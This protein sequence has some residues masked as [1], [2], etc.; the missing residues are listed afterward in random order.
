MISGLSVQ[1]LSR[2]LYTLEDSGHIPPEIKGG[3]SSRWD[4]CHSFLEL[5]RGPRGITAIT[6]ASHAGGQQSDQGRDQERVHVELEI[7]NMGKENWIPGLAAVTLPHKQWFAGTIQVEINEVITR[8]RG[9][10][11]ITPDLNAGG[12]RSDRGRDQWSV[13]LDVE[14]KYHQDTDRLVYCWNS[15][16]AV[17]IGLVVSRL[18][19]MLH[20]QEV[21]GSIPAEIKAGFPALMI[22][23]VVQRLSLLLNAQEVGCMILAEIKAE[24]HRP[25]SRCSGSHACLTRHRSPVK[26]RLRWIVGTSRPGTVGYHVVTR[27]SCRLNKQE[28]AGV[29]SAEII[30]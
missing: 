12:R 30:E 11:V 15:F 3:A 26:S 25:V 2:L 21:A 24:E 7:I 20:T 18:S 1:R 23:L 27:L 19:R 14:D 22:G 10:V 6:P 29:I 5:I 9:V 17:V 28:V 4:F 8:F 16:A 13:H